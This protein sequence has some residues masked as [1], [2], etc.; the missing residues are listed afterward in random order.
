MRV[1]EPGPACLARVAA[2]AALI[3][4]AF[5]ASV[6]AATAADRQRGEP[7]AVRGGG[8]SQI[9]ESAPDDIGPAV[10][11]AGAAGPLADRV[12]A[13]VEG[14]LE[15]YDAL[16]SEKAGFRRQ[17]WLPSFFLREPDRDVE[18]EPGPGGKSVVTV[19][20]AYARRD[21]E[22]RLVVGTAERF[23]LP[24]ADRRFFAEVLGSLAAFAPEIG[25]ARARFWFGVL[26]ADG[27]MMWESRGS[28]GLAGDVA[29]RFPAGARTVEAIWPLLDE[30]TLV[31]DGRR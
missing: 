12:R 11:R 30:N 24:D 19:H 20:I 14:S 13:Y 9:D 27:R 28:I 3:L 23:E 15:R 1:P 31:W 16:K 18:I 7:L 5:W 26:R 10:G 4:A 8:E 22:Q 25:R 6:P 2:I 17:G 29:R 21:L